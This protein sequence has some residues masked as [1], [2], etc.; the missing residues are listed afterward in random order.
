MLKRIKDAQKIGK[1]QGKGK[2]NREYF[3]PVQDFK[4]I[5]REYRGKSLDPDQPVNRGIIDSIMDLF[6]E[7]QT[8]QGEQIQT[9][10]VQEI[11]T[12]P[13]PDSGEPKLVA[14]APQINQATGLTTTQEAL[15]SP[16][17]KIIAQR[18]RT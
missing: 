12:P 13:L 4:K 7:R 18:Q 10:Q 5:E 17:E 2:V 15:L 16:S 11:Q 8:P 6:S 3:F 9:A 14:S 1:D